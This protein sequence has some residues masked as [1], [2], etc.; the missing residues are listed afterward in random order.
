MQSNQQVEPARSA[1]ALSAALPHGCGDT[2]DASLPTSAPDASEIDQQNTIARQLM[3]LIEL[4]QSRDMEL[5]SAFG[6]E[7]VNG[8]AKAFSAIWLRSLP[9]SI[10]R[11]NEM[12]A[13]S[14]CRG[15]A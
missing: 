14:S 9:P 11:R 12:D 8:T 1:F 13:L 6:A 10:L 4:A 5:A 3:R 7:L 2:I 15:A